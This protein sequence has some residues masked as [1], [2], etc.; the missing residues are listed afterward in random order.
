MVLQVAATLYLDAGN[1]AVA[2]F[3][4]QAGFQMASRMCDDPLRLRLLC[5]KAAAWLQRKEWVAAAVVGEEGVTL[6]R[7]LGDRFS[8]P[9]HP[10][11]NSLAPS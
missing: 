6:S 1:V 5:A 2:E 4:I 9:W 10:L 7:R 11:T 8:P 3:F